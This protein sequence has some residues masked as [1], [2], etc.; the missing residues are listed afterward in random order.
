MQIN[1]QG[2]ICHISP[3]SFTLSLLKKEMKITPFIVFGLLF[4]GCGSESTNNDLKTDNEEKT[5]AINNE[6]AYELMAKNCFA[7]H[8]PEG[9]MDS[10]MGPP[11]IAIKKHY[12]NDETTLEKFTADLV[13]FVN[14]PSE[15]D[16]KMPG[17]VKRFG[18]MPKMDFNDTDLKTIAKYL[19]ENEIDEPAWFQKHYEEERKGMG[20]N[21]SQ[22]TEA[23]GLKLALA[24]KKVLGTNLM[25]AINTKGSAY[26]VDFCHIKANQLIDSMSND[27]NAHI[28]RV[29][30]KP[31]N[32]KAM[33][34]KV[35]LAAITQFK[36]DLKAGKEL[37]GITTEY[38]D[39]TVGYYPITTN[40]M[41]IQ[42]H[43]QR[44]TD[45]NTETM[46]KLNE[47]YPNDKA[48]G[49]GINELRGIW[50]VDMMK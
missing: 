26:A 41:C 24:T 30:D 23:K 19:F 47:K 3:H 49:Y 25:G 33:A 6:A 12:I 10:R 29:T 16:A 7:C 39:K 35:E 37:S 17:A 20:N 11:M 40:Q 34:N 44:K 50:V 27:L 28:K 18:L 15:E 42:C 48:T 8:S 5:L 13:A 38:E 2:N 36:A 4:I 32:P 31:R 45:I 1:S 14:N 43:G 9:S 21:Q 22:S 46:A